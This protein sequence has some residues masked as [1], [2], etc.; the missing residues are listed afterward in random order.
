MTT[1]TVEEWAIIMQIVAALGWKD[2]EDIG[3]NYPTY[4]YPPHGDP[5]HKSW[6]PLRD[7]NES[8]QLLREAIGKS[9][10]KWV[11]IVLSE[12]LQVA[13]SASEETIM[14]LNILAGGNE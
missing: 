4:W 2:G 8:G 6:N 9:D 5:V 1:Q 12:S 13:M 10:R 11:D 3:A 7:R 14:A